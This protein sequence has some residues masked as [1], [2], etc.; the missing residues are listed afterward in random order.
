MRVADSENS[1][2]ESKTRIALF[3][4]SGFSKTLGLPTSKELSTKLLER[5]KTIKPFQ[6]VEDFIG[7]RIGEY[8]RAVFGWTSGAPEPSLGRTAAIRSAYLRP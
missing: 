8:W 5:V 1:D 7:A 3:L 6:K 2:I 4:G